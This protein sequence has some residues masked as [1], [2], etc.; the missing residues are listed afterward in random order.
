MTSLYFTEQKAENELAARLKLSKYDS[1]TGV[2]PMDFADRVH[3]PAPWGASRVAP[4]GPFPTKFDPKLGTMAVQSS[5][6]PYVVVAAV[7]A[8]YLLTRG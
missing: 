5:Y 1:G 4:A 8:M 7:A 3:F 6:L 2:M